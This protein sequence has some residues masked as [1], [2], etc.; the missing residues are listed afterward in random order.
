[1][2]KKRLKS[3]ALSLDKEIFFRYKTKKG[4]EPQKNVKEIEENTLRFTVF[5]VHL[6]PQTCPL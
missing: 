3:I 4:N 5:C 6:T 2:G 1:L